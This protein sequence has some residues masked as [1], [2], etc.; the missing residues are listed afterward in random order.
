MNW[1]R[2][3]RRQQLDEDFS[4]EVEAH[5][6]HEV[7]KN[8]DRGMSA[9][10][11]RAAAQRKFGNV[12]AAREKYHDMNS[13]NFIETLWQD[14]RQGARL[15]WFNKTFAIVA[16]LSLGLGMGANTAIFQLLDA[17]R[18]RTLPVKNPQEL[19]EIQITAN[20]G[21]MGDFISRRPMMTYPLYQLVAARQQ[22]FSEVVAW[23]SSRLNL[24]TGGEMRRAQGLWVS[25]TFFKSLGVPAI[26]GRTIT[27]DDDVKGCTN[28]GAVIS[29][30]F[31]QREFG[32]DTAI[33]R[34]I[35][36]DGQPFEVTGIT[37]ASFFGP[38]VGQSFDVA[39]P[40][41]ARASI[42]DR[43]HILDAKDVWWLAS[44]GR[45]KPGWSAENATSDLASISPA[46]FQETVP[47][48]Y[49][50]DDAK[51]YVNFKFHAVPSASGV[52]T[53]RRDYEA[54]LWILM[55]TTGFVLLIACA[56]IA[57]L[58]LARAGVRQREI[59]IRLAIG[60][61]RGRVIRQ[62]FAESLLL[63]TLGGIVA[64]AM[65]TA[66]SQILVSFLSTRGNDLYLALNADWRL[67]A[68]VAS[69]VVLTCTLFGLL[70]AFRATRV[71]P[72]A[73]M[74]A[75]G[76][77]MTAS[78]ERHRFRRVLVVTQ[79]AL[80]LVLLFGALLFARSLRNLLVLDSGFR[81]DGILVTNVDLRRLQYPEPQ[82]GVLY[83][84]ISRR[85]AGLAQVEGVAEASIVPI[86]G[87]GWNNFVVMAQDSSEK[88][89]LLTNFNQVDKGY[90]KTMGI[91][92]IGGR[93]FADTDSSSS[94]KVA[95]VDEPFV[96]K[97]LNSESPIGKHFQVVGSPG[98]LTPIYEIVGVVEA[99]K[100]FN[101]RDE[102]SPTI[103]LASAQDAHPGNQT[104]FV[105]RSSAPL[106][107]LTGS[108]KRVFAEL[109]PEIA[110]QFQ[111]L[112]SSVRDSLVRERL[113][114]TLTGFFGV[115]AAL[116][117]TIGLYGMLSYTVAQRR[118]EIGIRMALGAS[119]QKVVGM[120]LRE[121]GLL[122][123]VGIAVGVITTL[124][125]TRFAEGLL[126]G[127]TSKDP[128][129][130]S[131]AVLSLGAI[132]LLAGYIPARRAAGLQ[133]TTVLR[134][135]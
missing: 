32:G 125:L 113:M 128:M 117:S 62:L 59:S 55:A 126:Y 108:I 28:P 87:S 69:L 13:I 77:G 7:D 67:N 18:L 61:S 30:G 75:A 48:S 6:Q 46:I 95:I 36:L 29:Y 53:L 16:I 54:P 22:S 25:G 93:D 74:K 101:L 52:S 83:Q 71:G 11:A 58:M 47:A 76:R 44:M 124:Y 133:P 127:L 38:E 97:F 1:I 56:N 79:V 114:A 115:I 40:L 103:F 92:L 89:K 132:A 3:W 39:L 35:T 49:P 118:N 34:K 20:G 96:R 21:K 81:H 85:L 2:F 68:F 4:V 26:Q 23:G 99:S 111:V 120:I 31:W 45:L 73:A 24:S 42:G 104:S 91:S 80:S 70:P 65:G 50:P 43:P 66:C 15:L 51:N 105:L 12:T 57:N 14:L 110:I 33:G 17:V 116:L 84:D 37:P 88:K 86:S 98:E 63:A 27:E 129:T 41:C 64:I 131:A 8:M 19:V 60:A 134:D 130:L 109:H 9:D 122:V 94:P 112:S 5:I 102:F 82:R 90:F 100:Y 119:K 107:V 123:T 106:N 10:A 78:R 72:G 121:A 135:E